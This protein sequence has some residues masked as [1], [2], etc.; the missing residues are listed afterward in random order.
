MDT[1]IDADTQG[2]QQQMHHQAERSSAI[3]A[4]W[5]LPLGEQ[6]ILEHIVSRFAPQVSHLTINGSHPRLRDYGYPIIEDP[7]FAETGAEG[8]DLKSH[9]EGPQGPLAGLLA[10]LEYAEAMGLSWIATC[11]CDSPFL[12]QDYVSYLWN[13]LASDNGSLCAIAQHQGR[14]H[15]VFGIWS[16]E[17]ISPLR[18]T[19]SNSDFRAIGRWAKQCDPAVTLVEFA[20]KSESEN[21]LSSVESGFFNINTPEDWQ[22]AV[23]YYQQLQ[24]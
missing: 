3:S 17:L 15:P 23:A 24:Q 4:K 12:P 6:S 18:E 8:T 2:Y 22:H 19:L 10:G 20:H 11:P 5:Q 21:S 7:V 9:S 16:T 14:T 13:H 1:Y